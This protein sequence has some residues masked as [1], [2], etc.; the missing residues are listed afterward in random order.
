MTSLTKCPLCMFQ[1]ENGKLNEDLSFEIFSCIAFPYTTNTIC[2]KKN[3]FAYDFVCHFAILISRQD[4]RDV[5]ANKKK[6]YLFSFRY[7]KLF[8]HF[9]IYFLF[10]HILYATEEIEFR[11]GRCHCIYVMKFFLGNSQSFSSTAKKE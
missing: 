9:L 7:S 4:V 3:V 8:Y 5:S 2:C 6:L 10:V 1:M 11:F